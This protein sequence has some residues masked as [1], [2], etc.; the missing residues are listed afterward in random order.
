MARR[1]TEI[2][3]ALAGLVV[4]A[5]ALVAIATTVRVREGAPVIY[6]RRRVGLRGREFQLFKFRTMVPAGGSS[7]TVWADARV[8]PLGR[9]M[10]RLRLDELP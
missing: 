6:P 4:A 1:L 3:L 2:V 5:P 8:T 7:V 10:R 9:R